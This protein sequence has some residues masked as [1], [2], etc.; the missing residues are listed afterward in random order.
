[1]SRR[2]LIGEGTSSCR[3]HWCQRRRERPVGRSSLRETLPSRDTSDTMRTTLSSSSATTQAAFTGRLCRVALSGRRAD[4]TA[5]MH[6]TQV[7]SGEL[8]F[9][10]TQCGTASAEEDCVNEDTR[11]PKLAAQDQVLL[12]SFEPLTSTIL[13]QTPWTRPPSHGKYIH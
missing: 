5:C 11:N 10:A 9:L 12:Q 8:C 3:G 6:T 1:M 2:E 7:P 4:R 13:I